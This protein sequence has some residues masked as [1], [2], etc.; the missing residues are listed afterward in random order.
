MKNQPD[1]DLQE[2]QKQVSVVLAALWKAIEHT[3]MPIAM[4]AITR[5]SAGLLG[6]TSDPDHGST[7]LKEQ[8][9]GW[10]EIIADD[11]LENPLLYASAI[12]H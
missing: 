5:L 11:P 8:I 12:K 10:L 7:M 2:L 9:D 4:T 1:L 3:P 6:T